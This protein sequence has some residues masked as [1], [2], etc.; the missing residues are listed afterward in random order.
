MSYISPVFDVT[1]YG[2]IGDDS[3]DDTNPILA[4]V[5]A[6]ISAGGGCLYFPR[7]TY[8]ITAAITRTNFGC[9]LT[10]KGDGAKISSIKQY[11]ASAH[12]LY[13][14][15]G[16]G[17]VQYSVS[18]FDIGL[19]AA[20]TSTTCGVAITLA[21]G[22]NQGSSEDNVGPV[23]RGININNGGSAKGWSMGIALYTTWHAH[24]TDVYALGYATTG[25]STGIYIAGGTNIIVDHVQLEWWNTGLLADKGSASAA[26][27]GLQID[28]VQAIQCG[29]GVQINGND[30]TGSEYAGG[31]HTLSNILVDSGNMSGGTP[32]TPNGIALRLEGVREVMVTN[33][34]FLVAASG[35]NPIVAL[36]GACE[37]ALSNLQCFGSV[38]RGIRL[39][40]D[41]HIGSNNNLISGCFFRGQTYEV[42]C[43]SN[44][45]AN[46]IYGNQAASGQA[47]SNL[48]N[49]GSNI[50]GDA[51]GK[52]ISV[53]MAGSTAVN[54]DVDI[55]EFALGKKPSSGM[56]SKADFYEDSPIVGGYDFVNGASTKTNARFRIYMASGAALPNQTRAFNISVSP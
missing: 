43:D 35:S 24:V 34:Y 5:D 31:S 2:A 38:T 49:D 7:G 47:R 45:T 30:W 6:A 53:A 56:I 54:I 15:L 21:Y 26:S 4:A 48:D 39:S 44:C 36:V 1:K 13:F 10:I 22:T 55:T 20:N 46:R 12:G 11:T 41:A 52:Q 23:V 3:H 50:I 51:G 9:S 8:K 37:C 29:V 27:Q 42:V 40:V 14:D 17:N 32:F 19:I 33:C 18:I 16:N 25:N 28:S